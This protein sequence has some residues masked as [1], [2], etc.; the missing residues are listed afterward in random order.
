[1]EDSTFLISSDRE[2]GEKAESLGRLLREKATDAFPGSR[3]ELIE[4]V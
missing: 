4:K 3:L 2:L 1:L